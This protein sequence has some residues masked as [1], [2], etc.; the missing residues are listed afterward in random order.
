M[1]VS[2]DYSVFLCATSKD[3]CKKYRNTDY[4]LNVFHKTK[5]SYLQQISFKNIAVRSVKIGIN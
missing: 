1:V 5:N 4:F 2:I 3:H